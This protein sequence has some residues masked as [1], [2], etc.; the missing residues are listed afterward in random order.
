M[1]QNGWIIN[2]HLL[3]LQLHGLTTILTWWHQ[4]YSSWVL[5]LNTDKWTQLWDVPDRQCMKM[6]CSG[7]TN[8]IDF[9]YAPYNIKPWLNSFTSTDFFWLCVLTGKIEVAYQKT[10]ATCIV[11]RS[12]EV[13]PTP[14]DIFFSKYKASERKTKKTKEWN[15]TGQA[16]SLGQVT[17][18]GNWLLSMK[19]HKVNLS[20]IVV[21]RLLEWL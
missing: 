13:D 4:S 1:S 9:P 20:F 5:V 19:G 18:W 15:N 6:Q 16:G 17:Y 3:S 8:V 21:V 11:A 7:P 12:S 10:S 2:F 14:V